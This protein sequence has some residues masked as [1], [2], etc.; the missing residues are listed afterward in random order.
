MKIVRMVENE[1]NTNFSYIGSA[2]T[3]ISNLK[4]DISHKRKKVV[5][6]PLSASVGL[7]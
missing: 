2:E 7:I 1:K 4:K 3:D 6:N 5:F